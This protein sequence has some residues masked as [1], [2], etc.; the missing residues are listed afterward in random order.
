MRGHYPSLNERN[1]M[2]LGDTTLW[3]FSEPLSPDSQVQCPECREWSPI[4][5]WREGSVYCEDCGEHTAIVCPA[6]EERFDHVR[7]DVVFEVWN[8]SKEA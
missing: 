4:S 8:L 1:K 6:C 3:N 2:N 7:N 5:D